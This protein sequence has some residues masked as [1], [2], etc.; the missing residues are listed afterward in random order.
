MG[1]FWNHQSR[2]P[3]MVCN[4]IWTFDFC[5]LKKDSVLFGFQLVLLFRTA[6]SVWWWFHWCKFL[7]CPCIVWILWSWCCFSGSDA[8]RFWSSL[9]ISIHKFLWPVPF[10][11]WISRKSMLFFLI[12]FLCS[13]VLLSCSMHINPKALS[14]CWLVLIWIF[15]LQKGRAWTMQLLAVAC[16]SLAAKIE[17]TDV[18]LPLDLQVRIFLSN[19]WCFF[20]QC[21]GVACVDRCFS[22]RLLN[23][24]L[25][26]RLKQFKEWSFWS[27]AHWSGKCRLLLH[28]LLLITTFARLTMMEVHWVL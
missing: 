5:L 3:L 26:L 18:P 22:C 20:S 2:L 23:P 13:L 27:W 10:C 24:S 16:L 11:I 19:A 17:E 25:C 4:E 6:F 12:L 9:C 14:L 21:F 7:D 28:S 1:C 8:F 15:H